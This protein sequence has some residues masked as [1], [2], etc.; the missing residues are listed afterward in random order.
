[1]TFLH[2][3]AWWLLLLLVPLAIYF[4]WTRKSRNASLS[5]PSLEDIRSGGWRAWLVDL[6]ELM[7]LAAY[8]FLIYV[9]ARP[10]STQSWEEGTV[11]GIDIILALDVSTSM[12][13]QDLKPDRLSASIATAQQFVADRP[14]DNIGLVEFAGE[15]FT[16]CPI[17]LDHK[18]LVNQL[19]QLRM[20]RLIDGTAI[21]DALALSVARLKD[22]HS[23]SKV[24]ILLTD[25]ANTAGSITPIDAAKLAKEYGITVYTI[26]VGTNAEVAPYP[27]ITAFGTYIIQV[28]VSLDTE[29]LA[30]IA[31]QT[32][33]EAFR[34]TDNTSLSEIY[35]KIDELE[36]TKLKKQKYTVKAEHYQQYLL[37]AI[38]LLALAFILRNT[39]LR[40]VQ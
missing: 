30:K 20:G 8:V 18:I 9:I 3:K 7:L 33:G 38:F 31:S 28:P 40:K 25:G 36:K 26:A 17:T 19:H 4:V 1:M 32:G 35:K 23:A 10:Q 14:N 6:P 37:W 15:A 24:V 29:M 16:S 11:E 39:V 5:M 2:P 22:S 27:Q 21:G 12:L 34:A 13:A